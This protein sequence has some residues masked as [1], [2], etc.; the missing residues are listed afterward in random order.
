MSNILSFSNWT[1]TGVLNED[2]SLAKKYLFNRYAEENGL[3]KLTPDDEAKALD[4]EIYK[5]IRELLRNNNGYVYAFVKFALDHN[6]PLTAP[7]GEPSLTLLYSLIRKHAGS[8]NTLPMSIQQYAVSTEPIDGLD[9]FIALVEAFRNMDRDLE[10]RQHRNKYSWIINKVNSALRESIKKMSADEL[11]RLYK[12]AEVIDEVDKLV[13]DFV[14]PESGKVTNN[15]HLILIKSNAYSDGQIY[16]Q[17]VEDL[18]EGIS[19]VDML[20]KITEVKKVSPNAS[21]IYFKYPYLVIAVR[22]E[23]AQKELFKIVAIPWCI[24]RGHW[25]NYG[26]KPDAL[27]YN[28]FDYS[29]N[30]ND[31]F[32]LIGNTVGFDGALRNCHDRND[33]PI[34]KTTNWAENLRQLGYPDDLINITT[35]SVVSEASLKSIIT[36]LGLNISDLSTLLL[37]LIK[38]SYNNKDIESDPGINKVILGIIKDNLLNRLSDDKIL[39]VYSKNSVFTP[40]SARILNTLIPNMSDSEKNQIL[41]KTNISINSLKKIVDHLGPEYNIRATSIVDDAEAIKEIIISGDTLTIPKD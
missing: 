22:T 9:S 7:E 31:R 4:I 19:N 8:L 16:L 21:V 13:G 29:K 34:N 17:A 32:H 12:A 24:N 33:D 1:S 14:D 37:T 36:G 11:D 39:E 25:N 40:F 2:I 10:L 27:Q 20:D 6:A 3:S 26:G 41:E 38:A 28:I 5:Q 18:A 23:D 30:V 15:H 35:G